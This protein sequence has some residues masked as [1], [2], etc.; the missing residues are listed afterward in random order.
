MVGLNNGQVWATLAGSSTLT[1][2]TGS[3]P[4]PPKQVLRVMFDPTDATGNT[5]YVTVGGYWGNAT[6]HVFKTTN[7][8]AGGVTW[9]GVSGSGATAIPDV[10]VNCIVV[11]PL[12]CQRLY[13]CTDVGVC[14]S[15][16]GGTNWNPLGTGLPRVPVFEM[17]FTAGTT[18]SR[19]LRIA[20]ARSRHV[21]NTAASLLCDGC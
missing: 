10:P 2:V 6:G 11:D 18:G 17:A 1:N 7:L 15:T 14:F 16:N 5:A 12:R 9:T 3:L 13:A 4:T 20:Y 19:S 8:S 21:E